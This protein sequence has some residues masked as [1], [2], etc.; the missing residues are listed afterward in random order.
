[1]IFSIFSSRMSLNFIMC[2][3]SVRCFFLSLIKEMMNLFGFFEEFEKFLS[4][5]IEALV[6]IAFN[7]FDAGKV[8]GA[9]IHDFGDGM[10]GVEGVFGMT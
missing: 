8:V 5:G 9:S 7:F 4:E 1:M 2:S 10:V 3:R 6:E